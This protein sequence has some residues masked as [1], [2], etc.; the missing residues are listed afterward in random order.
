MSEDWVLESDMRNLLYNLVLR[1][2]EMT[3]KEI[4]VHVPEGAGNSGYYITLKGTRDE[5]LKAVCNLYGGYLSMYQ[6]VE[7]NEQRAKENQG[8]A[9]KVIEE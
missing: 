5:I 8:L 4:T 2:S 6:H 9:S 3:D 7:W 1:G